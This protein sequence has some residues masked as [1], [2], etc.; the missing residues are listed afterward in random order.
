MKRCVALAMMVCL[1]GT[2]LGGCAGREDIAQETTEVARGDLEIIVSVNGNLEMPHKMDLSFGTVGTVVEV[3]VEEGDSVRDGQTLAR[4]DARSL[5]LA[6]EMALARCEAAQAEYEMADER[7][8]NTIY[9]HYYDTYVYDLP[10]TWMALKD[11]QGDLDEARKLL[12]EGKNTEAHTM[13]DLVEADLTKAKEK[14]KTRPWELPLSVKLA[15]LQTD[16]AKASLDLAKLELASASL[17]LEKATIVATFDGIVAEVMIKEGEELS[18]MAAGPAIRLIDP[19]RIEMEGVIDEIDVAHVELGQEANISLD[20]LPDREIE[21]QVTFISQAGTVQ[22][23]VVS[24]RTTI[25]LRETDGKLRDGMSATADIVIDRREDV[26]LIPNR[27]IRGSWDSPIVEVVVDGEVERRQ[28]TLG[29]SDGIDTEV[30]S[31]LE[32]GEMVVFPES[33]LP[34]RMFGG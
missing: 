21:G 3:L 2:V 25:A 5:E 8:M 17:E 13:L 32:E 33:Q 4:L 6:V 12:E 34:F 10:G 22:A 24:Y 31:G 16:Q 7:L 20:A 15:E 11:A 18:A 26:L 9:P 28:I 30:L 27:A 29:L 14:S 19:G 23:G 1:A